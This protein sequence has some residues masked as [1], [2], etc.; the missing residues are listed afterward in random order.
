MGRITSNVKK[1]DKVRVKLGTKLGWR[2]ARVVRRRGNKVII[3]GKFWSPGVTGTLN[4]KYV[5]KITK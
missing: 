2:D 3:T 1:G 4:K 5:K